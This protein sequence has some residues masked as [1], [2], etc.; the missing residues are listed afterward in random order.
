M[1]AESDFVVLAAPL[2][3]E[4]QNMIDAGGA[5]RDEARSWLINVARGGL[6]DERALLE[7]CATGRWRRRPRHVPGRAAPADLAVLRPAER[8][9]HAPHVLVERPRPRSERRA[10]LRQPPALR[11]RRTAAERRRRSDRGVLERVTRPMQI[12]IVGPCRVG[13]TTVFNTLTR[14]HAETG[15]FGGIEL[16]SRRRQGPRRAPRS[17]WP[18]SSSR[19]RSSRRC[20][21]RRPAGAAGLVGGPCRR[22]GPA[23][24]AP[25]PAARVRT[26][27]STSSALSR[28][29][30]TPIPRARSTRPATSTGSTPEFVL[31]D[32]ALV[33]RRLERLKASGRHGTPAERESNEREEA[34]LVRLNAALEAGSPIR[35]VCARGRRGEG[36]PRLPVPDPEAGPRPAERRRERPGRGRRSWSPRS[37]RPT[38][39]P[40]RPDRRP[41]GEDRDGARGAGAR[42]GRGLHGGARDRRVGPR[43]GHRPVATGCSD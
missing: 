13:K 23:G 42:R 39:T 32:L 11:G 22:R 17:G 24:R 43:P 27:C 41:L 18:R 3:P 21:L 34:I 1:L 8:H 38:T 15:G 19:R 9:R 2:T 10:V 36:N 16:H 40:E 25:R 12:A 33:E 37:P 35:D 5:G 14:G 7:R 29:P 31:A 6:V 28:T 4:T 20:H 30:R 26:R